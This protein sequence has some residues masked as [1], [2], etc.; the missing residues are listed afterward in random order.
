MGSVI[1][2][3]PYIQDISLSRY[4]L[5]VMVPCYNE[6]LT[7]SLVVQ[8]FREALPEAEIYV[9]DNRSTD[10]TAVQAQAAG[11][12]VHYEHAAG[13]GHVVRRMFADIEA[14]IYILVDGDHTYDASAVRQLITRLIN[15]ELDVVVGARR[16]PVHSSAYRLGHRGGNLFLTSVVQC[17]FGKRLNDM[18]SG[19]RVMSRR[20]VKSFPAL[21]NG[22][23]TETELTIHALELNIPF[24]EEPTL[25]AARPEGSESKLKT[26]S[27]GWRI[28]GTALLLFK[29]IRPFLFFSIQ[30]SF[31]AAISLA[32]GI[33]IIATYWETGLVP[34]FPTAILATA[35]ML[36]AFLSLTCGL[37][38]DSVAR[39]RRE[40]KRMHYL[41]YPALTATETSFPKQK[42]LES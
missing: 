7:I 10:G 39:G 27:D 42:R 21:S 26:F 9:Y 38:L 6:A 15:E 22:F 31:L 23:E 41:N 29:E 28:L 30:A 20:F 24:A 12:I 35:I 2:R 32:L 14:D 13:K 37:I 25:F 5:V 8:S 11:A 1:E 4:R 16:S 34:R 17:L 19:Y 18:L 3:Q 36:L 40:Q 33:P